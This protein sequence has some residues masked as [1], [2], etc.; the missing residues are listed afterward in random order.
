[1]AVRRA[2]D[3]HESVEARNVHHGYDRH[4]R[5]ADG[6]QEYWTVQQAPTA[7]AMQKVTAS[8]TIAVLMNAQADSSIPPEI[9]PIAAL[10]S[11]TSNRFV[12]RS[13]TRFP[14]STV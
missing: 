6:L 4:C 13:L 7:A 1:M 11:A 2:F 5:R 10:T 14:K 12:N 9:A 8:A 3:P